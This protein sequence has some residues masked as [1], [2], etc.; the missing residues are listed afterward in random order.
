MSEIKVSQCCEH[1][2]NPLHCNSF[3]KSR[4]PRFLSYIRSLHLSNAHRE[5]ISEL[6][7]L[8][9]SPACPERAQASRGIK[10]EIQR[11]LNKF[12]RRT[13]V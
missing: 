9:C 5:L 13:S 6:K 11:G 3:K 4:C 2:L 1:C 10:G 12:E 7:N 8:I